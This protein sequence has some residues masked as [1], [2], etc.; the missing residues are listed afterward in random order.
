LA[1]VLFHTRESSGPYRE[2]GTEDA[3]HGRNEISMPQEWITSTLLIDRE[4]GS[5]THIRVHAANCV[6]N[7]KINLHL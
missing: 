5:Y 2:A 4:S 1:E 7:V 3:S 6:I